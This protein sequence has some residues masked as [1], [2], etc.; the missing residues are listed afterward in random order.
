[1]ISN[2]TL[3][4]AMLLVRLPYHLSELTQAAALAALKNRTALQQQV[5]QIKQSR[6]LLVQELLKMGL[7]VVPSD[8]NFV[9][10]SGFKVSS[11]DLW[12]RLVDRDVLIRDVGI[13]G[14]LRVT[15]G[16][17]AEN[18]AFLTALQQALHP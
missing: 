12:Q 6:D 7:Q 2:R 15:I 10:F 11:Q 16:T 9:M 4:E 1:M 18:N 3:V 8:A 14:Y 5:E 13:P 17:E